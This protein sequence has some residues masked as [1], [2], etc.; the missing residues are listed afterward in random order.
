MDEQLNNWM[1]WIWS[2]R[3][4]ALLRTSTQSRNLKWVSEGGINSPRHQTSRWLKAAESSTIGWS[5]AMLFRVSVHLVLLVV[6]LHCTWLLT[7]LLRRTIGSSG[8]EDPAVKTLLLAS[9]RPSDELLMTRPFIRCYCVDLGAS[10]SCLNS[11]TRWTDGSLQWSVGSFDSTIFAALFPNSSDA[12]RKGTVGSSGSIKLT[13]VVARCTKYSDA[14][15]R[16]CRRFI[17]RCL[18]PSF[19]SR[20]Q[21]GSLLQLNILSMPSLIAPKYI[22]S[23]HFAMR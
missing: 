18:F 16:W 12:I 5:D 1:D 7:L 17:Q 6:A 15:H 19:S 3:C 20:L 4:L 2:S 10:L 8:A 22:L 21:L 23:P 9:T 14:M 11:T 13:L